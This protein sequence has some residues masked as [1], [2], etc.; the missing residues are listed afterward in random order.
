HG[1]LANSTPRPPSP[2]RMR[3]EV[4][5][6]HLPS[7]F[8]GSF[9][10][11]Q[12]FE[13]NPGWPRDEAGEPLQI[14][15]VEK[16]NRYRRLR[17]A[18]LCELLA[19]VGDTSTIESELMPLLNRKELIWSHSS[20]GLFYDNT[21]SADQGCAP[22]PRLCDLACDTILTIV[23][24]RVWDAYQAAAA[25]ENQGARPI[26]RHLLGAIRFEGAGK[27]IEFQGRPLYPVVLASADSKIVGSTKDSEEVISGTTVSQ[28]KMPVGEELIRVRDRMLKN[29]ATGKALSRN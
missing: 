9:K 29:L 26:A 18:R 12:F 27:V 4:R 2:H 20:P 17:D 6:S 23:G 3:T 21:S 22:A 11:T 7:Y 28:P 10:Q 8:P 14:S 5:V 1:M 24:V 25:S 16:I 13:D 19:F 15:R